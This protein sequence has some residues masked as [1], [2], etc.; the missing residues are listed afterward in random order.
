M[1]AKANDDDGE[2]R[3]GRLREREVHR[4]GPRVV[5]PVRGR[6]LKD[7]HEHK[8]RVRLRERRADAELAQVGQRAEQRR[9]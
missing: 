6:A 7:G 4:F 5:G 3:L 9:A 8:V 2:V 1:T